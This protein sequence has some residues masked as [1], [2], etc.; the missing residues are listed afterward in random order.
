M[1]ANCL[2]TANAADLGAGVTVLGGS[3]VIANCT[4]AGNTAR[5]GGGLAFGGGEPVVVGCTVVGNTA[6]L[7]G[8]AFYFGGS[9]SI[10]TS[11]IWSNTSS[12]G[13]PPIESIPGGSTLSITYSCVQGGWPGEGNISA[14]PMLAADSRSA[15]RLLPGSPCIDAGSNAAFPADAAD[16]DADGDTTEPL[17]LDLRGLPRFIDDPGVSEPAGVP[18]PVADMGSA[19]F[20]ADA[21]GCP[22]DWDA[23]GV[24]NSRDLS[25][26][27]GAWGQSMQ[28]GPWLADM[29]ANG[30]IDS[31]DISAFLERWLMD[32]DGC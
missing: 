24:S 29:N 27:L 6:G 19:E 15:Y 18:P 13:G 23:D 32:V 17:P 7:G 8:A 30:V 25:A 5:E 4:L 14:D 12:K 22:G 20:Q 11:I 28:L 3:P 2:I 26:F 16:L 9:P 31:G 1:V 21:A 10:S